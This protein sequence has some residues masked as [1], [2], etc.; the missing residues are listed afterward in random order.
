MAA[1]SVNVGS[2]RRRRRVVDRGGIVDRPRHQVAALVEH[3]LRSVEL[4][5]P[6][7][8]ADPVEEVR[9]VHGIG[10]A[11]RDRAFERLEAAL[12]QP[13]VFDRPLG[14]EPRRARAVGTDERV[15]R[16]ALVVVEDLPEAFRVARVAGCV[17][18]HREQLVAECGV[19]NFP[20][21]GHG[22][23]IR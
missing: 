15:P 20:G 7:G 11:V 22:P 10:V 19:T 6:V 5:A 4:I 3:E 17:V 16:P 13:D 18:G 8:H 1:C 21:A 2:P 12:L 9:Q 23:R 14:D